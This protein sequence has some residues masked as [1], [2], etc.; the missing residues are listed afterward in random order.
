MPQ[1]TDPESSM[2]QTMRTNFGSIED[3]MAERVQ[4]EQKEAMNH[5]FWSSIPSPKRDAGLSKVNTIGHIRKATLEFSAPSLEPGSVKNSK[6]LFVRPKFNSMIFVGQ[7]KQKSA[8][9]YN[10]SLNDYVSIGP[11]RMYQ[12]KQ[13]QTRRKTPPR[14][15]LTSTHR[16]KTVSD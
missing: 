10:L 11:A 15:I 7:V 5:R 16:I 12:K 3:N 13:S 6:L 1:V 14:R 8:E 4:T 9:Q 2:K